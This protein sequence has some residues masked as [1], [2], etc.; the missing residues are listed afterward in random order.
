MTFIDHFTCITD[1][2]T[3]PTTKCIIISS[4]LLWMSPLETIKQENNVGIVD[5]DLRI[6]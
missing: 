2:Y 4:L 6:K 3:I 5:N 1:I